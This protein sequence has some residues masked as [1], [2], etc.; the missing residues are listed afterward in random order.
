MLQALNSQQKL[1]NA[2]HAKPGIYTCP[3]CNRPVVLKKGKVKMPH[4]AH[5]SIKDC[6]MY[7]YKKETVSHIEG[8][9]ALYELFTPQ[10]CYMEYY[11]PEIEQ[12][13]DCFHHTGIALELQM[14]V[15]PINHIAAR[16]A[17]YGSIG[18]DVIWIA[19]FQDIK[20]DGKRMKL[21]HFQSALIHLKG[22]VLIAY[23]TELKTFFAL[24]ILQIVNRNTFDIEIETIQSGQAL[25]QAVEQSQ[26]SRDYR[27]IS[28]LESKQYIQNCL[29]KKSVLEPTLSGLYQLGIDRRHIPKYL[30]VVLREQL[31]INTYP[32]EW[33]VGL[34]I[35]IQHKTF[36]FDKW[37][38]L[39]NLTEQ[40][41]RLMSHEQ[42]A[43]QIL[44]NYQVTSNQ[45]R[46]LITE[47]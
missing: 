35:M 19:K 4:F 8:K 17:G 46:A 40:S 43:F 30:R 14:S 47:K 16:S 1:V 7:I 20:I 39:L 44:K 2:Q 21:T 28:Q 36:N 26:L 11:L 37:M 38:S 3:I 9:Y 27:I 6:F 31:Y 45:I 12:I 32:I 41:K 13:P 33:Q 22:N 29:A 25:L 34:M 24:H 15:I 5:Q 10:T 23:H 42:L 18:I